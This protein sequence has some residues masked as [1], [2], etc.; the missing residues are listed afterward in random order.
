MSLHLEND[1]GHVRASELGVD[2]FKII[3]CAGPAI[4]HHQHRELR[5]VEDVTYAFSTSYRA[6]LASERNGVLLANIP[7]HTA[8][9]CRTA[10]S[11]PV[12]QMRAEGAALR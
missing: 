6:E 11:R 3:P 5:Q 2:L 7:R 10:A 12:T 8:R 1:G 4:H 9:E